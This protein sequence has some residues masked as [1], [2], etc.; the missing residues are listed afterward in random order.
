MEQ[1]IENH[2][3]IMELI[4]AFLT[5]VVGPVLYLLVSKYLQKQKDKT[6][7][8][9]KE[10][11]SSVSLISNELEEIGDE[12]KADRVWIA[13]FHNGGNFYPTGKSIQKFSI[14]YEV[15]KLV[16]LQYLTP[17]TIYLVH[18]ILKHLNIQCMEIVYSYQTLQTLKS[19]PS[20]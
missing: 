4:G 19:Q 2:N 13:Q 10:N 18:Y 8:I 9:V 5:G 12:F 14:F 17:L 11:I 20:D 6:R 3:H 16:Y 1:I 15:P 7:D